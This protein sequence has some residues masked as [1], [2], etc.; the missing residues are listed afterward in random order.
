[1]CK[2]RK[3]DR[4]KK[5]CTK[6]TFNASECRAESVR[7]VIQKAKEIKITEKSNDNRNWNM[8]MCN[9]CK[10]LSSF[11]IIIYSLVT[12]WG[13]VSKTD[14]EFI[15]IKFKTIL[16]FHLVDWE[17]QNAKRIQFNQQ[18]VFHLNLNSLSFFYFLPKIRFET[19]LRT[20][21]ISISLSWWNMRCKRWIPLNAN[22]NI[23]FDEL[24]FN[25]HVIH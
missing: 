12:G 4:K 25:I 22:F 2:N 5:S 8:S 15:R 9:I 16:S 6:F 13:R 3:K 23:Q 21:W 24:Q 14:D 18:N 7:Y 19:T 11:I 1:M 10:I 17:I 20:M